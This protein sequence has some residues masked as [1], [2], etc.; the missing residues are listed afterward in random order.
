MPRLA[1]PNAQRAEVVIYA[2]STDDSGLIMRGDG[3]LEA[4]HEPDLV[5]RTPNA[6]VVI[7]GLYRHDIEARTEALH[8]AWMAA[9]FCALYFPPSAASAGSLGLISASSSCTS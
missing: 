1:S 2:I 3:I 4:A 6:L 5:V 9:A 8:G 7:A